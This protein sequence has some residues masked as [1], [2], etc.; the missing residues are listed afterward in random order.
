[1]RF[2]VGNVSGC[3]IDMGRAH[4]EP[5]IASLPR[6][7]CIFWKSLRMVFIDPTG[8]AAFQF[9]QKLHV[10]DCL[11]LSNQQVKVIRCSIDG[12]KPA[13]EIANDSTDV[14]E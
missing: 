2:L 5:A 1:M 14:F 6:K 9:F 7:P 13:I 4:A 11:R 8:T 12:D 10:C 3:R